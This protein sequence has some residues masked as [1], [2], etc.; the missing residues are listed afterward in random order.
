M[1]TKL[2][3]GYGG[4]ASIEST[5]LLITGGSFDDSSTISYLNMIKTPPSA[6]MTGR[7]QHAWGTKSYSGSLSFDV[8]DGAMALFA[9]SGGLLERYYEFDVGINDG[10]TD[11][12][13]EDCKLT[14]LTLSGSVGGLISS[15]V[16]FMSTKTKASGGT[17]HVFIR[18]TAVP[19]AYWYSGIGSGDDIRDWS[20]SMTQEVEP[21][22]KNIDSTISG[23][24][25]AYL[26]VGLVSYTLSV[27]SFKNLT[28]GAIIKVGGTTFTLTGNTAGKGFSFTGITDVGAYSYTF[29]TSS[30][31]GDSDTS[32]IVS[33]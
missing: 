22:Y 30:D 16:S 20:L 32:V 13:M 4:S 5:Q 8:H 10:V 19:M 26:K 27:T 21:V 25:P 9:S 2:L 12:K 11:W 7:V 3:L 31:D 14:S 24:S 15:Q 18:D 29:E 23:E 1:A 33:S 6:I 28:P 17:P